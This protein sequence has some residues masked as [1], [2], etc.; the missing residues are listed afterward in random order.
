MPTVLVTG[1]TVMQNSPFSSLAEAITIACVYPW[2][3]DQAELAWVINTK[4]AYPRM[5]THLSTNPTWCGVT[6]LIWPMTLPPS[7][8][9]TTLHLITIS[10]TTNESNEVWD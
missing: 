3:D 8:T 1:P 4:M 7:Q 5:V 6:L 9:G 2:R 10:C